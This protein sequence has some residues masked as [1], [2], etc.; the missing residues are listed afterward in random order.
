MEQ[1]KGSEHTAKPDRFDCIDLTAVSLKVGQRVMTLYDIEQVPAGAIGRVIMVG[2]KVTVEWERIGRVVDGEPW[3]ATKTDFD[4]EMMQY[5]A[6]E[7][8]NS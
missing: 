4:D 6:L 1:K 3:I 5:L 2:D 7:E 8:N